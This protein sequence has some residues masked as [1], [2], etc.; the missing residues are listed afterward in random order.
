VNTES[1]S[2]T[3]RTAK[4]TCY[5]LI[6]GI[7]TDVLFASDQEAKTATLCSSLLLL[8][9]EKFPVQWQCLMIALGTLISP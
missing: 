2:R 1:F 9:G 5:A 4:A 3:A 6:C 7:K 8:S